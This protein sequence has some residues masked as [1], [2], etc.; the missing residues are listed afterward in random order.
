MLK[1]CPFT[2]A[3]CC[4]VNIATHMA[5]V[6]QP[7]RLAS[8]VYLCYCVLSGNDL[9]SAIQTTNTEDQCT[10][11]P[12]LAAGLGLLYLLYLCDTVTPAGLEKSSLKWSYLYKIQEAEMKEI[13]FSLKITIQDVLNPFLSVLCDRFSVMYLILL[14]VPL[15]GLQSSV[16]TWI[17]LMLWVVMVTV[18]HVS[19]TEHRSLVSMLKILYVCSVHVLCV[20]S[21][22]LPQFTDKVTWSFQTCTSLCKS[23]G[24]LNSCLNKHWNHFYIKVSTVIFVRTCNFSVIL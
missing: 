24:N 11:G 18:N 5:C 20:C 2:A 14:S 12:C 15:S 19:T 7:M 1:S 9:C 17:W 8:A 13:S 4:N 10:T 23:D 3:V 16:R 22:L 21:S 6:W